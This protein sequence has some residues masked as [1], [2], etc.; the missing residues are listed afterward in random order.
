MENG[1]GW[2]K[3]AVML[4]I[5][6]GA[7]YF[8]T[9]IGG[10]VKVV[11]VSA[12]AAYILDP[13]AGFLE[14]RGLGRT[15]ATALIF[16][17]IILAAVLFFY[18]VLPV[19]I[20]EIKSVE[21]GPAVSQAKEG[22]GR[23]ETFI[24]EKA[25]P[26]GFER[27]DLSDRLHA[28]VVDAGNG[29]LANISGAFSLLSNV[30]F[31]PFIIFFLLKDGREFKKKFIGMMPNRYF[32]FSLNLIYKMDLQLGN[33]LRGQVLDACIVGV[34]STIALWL[35][36][37]RY[38][39]IIGALAGLANLIPYFGPVVGAAVAVSV[40]VMNTWS[41]LTAMYIVLA[42]LIIKLIDDA[43]VQP[44]VMARMV[45]LHPLAIFLVILIGGELSGLL[46]LLLAVP[47]AGMLKVAI[48]EI[49][50]NFRRYRRMEPAE[51]ATARGFEFIDL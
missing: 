22:L 29:L 11:M 47:I 37:V 35:L 23:L 3:L 20:S 49:V 38:F 2:I 50:I 8:C 28:A 1:S 48:E 43:I 39:Y 41:F 36:G 9:L 15:A 25:V 7:V 34:L 30:V 19:I 31:I 33:Y 16:I 45:N 42:F 46:G 17:G 6:A 13:V 5:A 10:L 27:V 4:L 32:E 14:S 51:P 24:N 18:L 44:M 26:A 40:S 12:L 21:S